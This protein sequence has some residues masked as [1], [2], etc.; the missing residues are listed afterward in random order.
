MGLFYKTFSLEKLNNLVGYV[1]ET[2]ATT[3]LI[4]VLISIFSQVFCR[5]L[6]GFSLTWSEEIGRFLLI[7]FSYIGFGALFK[8]KRLMSIRIIVERLPEKVQQVAAI[9][10]SIFSLSFLAIVCC[11]GFSLVRLTM[12]QSAVV[13]RIP[14]GY[15]YSALPLG[16][17]FYI[18]HLIIAYLRRAR[19]KDGECSR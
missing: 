1:A 7:W 2:A 5:F 15:I 3:C 19:K 13:T 16:A 9:L 8:E 18:L 11:Y 12:S 10:G 17:A 6:L 14:M 4:I